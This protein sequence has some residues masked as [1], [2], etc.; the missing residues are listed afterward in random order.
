VTRRGSR[1]IR[2]HALLHTGLVVFVFPLVSRSAEDVVTLRSNTRLV[3]LGVIAADR[4][5]RPVA[6]LTRDNFEIYDQGKRQQIRIFTTDSMGSDSSTRAPAPARETFD[7]TF[8]NM[9][10][11][12]SGPGAVTV[13]L[14]DSLNTRWVNQAYARKQLLKFLEQIHS[15]DRIAIYSMGYGGFHVLHDFTQDA[16]DLM[17]KLAA[18]KGEI[19]APA[20][21]GDSAAHP[22]LGQQ[23]AQWLN[24]RDP[25]LVQSQLMG[26]YDHF[27]PLQ[28]L[29]ILTA[30]ANQLA[31]IPG[32]KN[33]IW[34][35]EGFPLADFSSLAEA[36]WVPSDVTS[37]MSRQVE[38]TTAGPERG[39][40][41]PGSFYDEMITAMRTISDD[42]VAIYPVNALPLDNPVYNAANASPSSMSA[43]NF[44]AAHARQNVMDDIAKRTGGMAFYET[45]DLAHAIRTAMEDSKATYTIG[46]YPDVVES[47]GKFHALKVRV[48]GRPDVRLRYRQ[49]YIDSPEPS[50]D[51]RDRRV[52]LENAAWSP[53]DA[54]A[55]GLSVKIERAPASSAGMDRVQLRVRPTDLSFTENAAARV[56]EADLLI[57]QK[58]ERGKQLDAIEQV[59]RL[60]VNSKRYEELTRTGILLSRAFTLD[61]NTHS[62]R[63]VV[64]DVHSDRLGSISIPRAAL[65]GQSGER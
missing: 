55:I 34:I 11:A 52:R 14:I 6:S 12:R 37:K 1:I 16:A 62:L 32:R 35:S 50:R 2:L 36:V 21:S 40:A 7:D 3:Q 23:L 13:I 38:S 59:I 49:G 61:R 28:G 22:D 46:F 65:I 54:N 8:T 19:N 29:K 31:G 45:N 10:E 5:G 20:P 9:A 44:Q 18:L 33:L 24:G 39:R 26:D 30:V 42:N 60:E 51:E 56:A 41:E 48:A 53:L 4:H 17:A 15:D 47:N 43:V 27:G 64:S 25:E 57:V 63:V 58:D